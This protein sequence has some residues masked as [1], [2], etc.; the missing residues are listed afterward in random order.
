MVFE[1]CWNHHFMPKVCGLE[2]DLKN[3][4]AKMD[5][6]QSQGENENG[7]SNES[8]TSCYSSHMSFRECVSCP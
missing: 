4:S 8:E 3:E 7:A 6:V 5:K 1:I 2:F